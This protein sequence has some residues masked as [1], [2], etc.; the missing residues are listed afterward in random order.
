MIYPELPVSADIASG[1]HLV[2]DGNAWCALGPEFYDLAVSAVGWGSSPE[3]ARNALE[4]R[5]DG[6]IHVPAIR[7][8]Q[9]HG[10]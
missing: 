7:E 6:E 1:W 3:A 10:L 5:C 2:R 4:A 9:V 8:F